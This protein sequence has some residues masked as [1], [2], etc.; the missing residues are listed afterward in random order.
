[1]TLADTEALMPRKAKAKE[2]ARERIKTR[3]EVL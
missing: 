2:K 1:M 3:I